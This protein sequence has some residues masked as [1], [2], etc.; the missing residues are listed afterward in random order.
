MRDDLEKQEKKKMALLDTQRHV[1]ALREAGVSDGQ[2]RAHVGVLQD[3]LKEGVATTSDLRDVR[4]EMQELRVELRA[5]MQE[6]RVELRA[7]MRELRAEMQEMR[8]EMKELRAEMQAEMRELRAE[9]KELRAEMQA[10]MREL[11]AEM[12]EMRADSQAE[13]K[14]IRTEIKG[15]DREM[16]VFRRVFYMGLAF[17]AFWGPTMIFAVQVLLK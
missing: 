17:M 3:A 2:S 16:V 11:R 13:M 7:E 8:A 15:F 12:K 9:M 10:E 6:L 1:D 5:E 4:A 14:E